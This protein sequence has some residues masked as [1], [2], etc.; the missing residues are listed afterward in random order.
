MKIVNRDLDIGLS[1]RETGT[2]ATGA[3]SFCDDERNLNS[4]VIR[5]AK[6]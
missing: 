3:R 1:H 4:E 2:N 5:T 6:L